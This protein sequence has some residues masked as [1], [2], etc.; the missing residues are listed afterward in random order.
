MT[1]FLFNLIPLAP[2]DGNSV[3]NGIVPREVAGWLAPL[4]TYGPLILT[5][6]LLIGFAIP[7][8]N[9]LGRILGEC[10]FPYP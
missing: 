3:L 6:L 9:I 2:L 10:E 4:R 7:G 8:V 1:L 5:G